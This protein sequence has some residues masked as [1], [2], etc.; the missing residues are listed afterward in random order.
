MSYLVWIDGL[1]GPEAQL[2][3]NGDMTRDGKSIETLAKHSL[4]PLEAN[5]NLDELKRRY[6]YEAK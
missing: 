4:T 2:W 1:R 6:P 5:L 3:S